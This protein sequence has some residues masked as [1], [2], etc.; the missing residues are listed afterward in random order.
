MI[1]LQFPKLSRDFELLVEIAEPA[2]FVLR[3]PACC[4]YLQTW[5]F[6]LHWSQKTVHVFGVLSSI[7]L[8]L[9]MH[10]YWQVLEGLAEGL[11]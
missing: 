2:N 9:L 11:W 4:R 7:S 8:R 1:R 5:S 3:I 10:Q 6:H